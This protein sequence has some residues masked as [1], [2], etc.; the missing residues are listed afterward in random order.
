M[1]KYW[2][3]GVKSDSKS[4]KNIVGELTSSNIKKFL[5]NSNDIL[6]K[7]IYSYNKKIEIKAI[8]I[9]GLV[10][11]NAVDEYIL[12][13]LIVGRPFSEVKSEK[14]AYTIA[15]EGFLYHISQEDV[16]NLADAVT[17]ILEGNTVVVFDNIKK[18]FSFDAKGIPQRSIQEP[19]NES[20]L[21]GAKDGF[22]ENIRTNTALVRK[23]VKSTEIRFE[24]Y[25][26]GEETN[27]PVEIVYMN[28]VVDIGVLTKLKEKL[29]KLDISIMISSD[30]FESNIKD[31]KYSIFPQ[32]Q[33][34]ERVDKFCAN[35]CDGKVGILIDG[36]PVGYIVPG[37]FAMF[38][39]APED[40]AE[41]YGTASFLRSIRY[42]CFAISLIL[43]AFYVAITT[44]HHEM[45]PTNL[46]ISI[47]KSKEGVPFS[48]FFEILGLLVA[49]E[50]LLEASLRLPKTIGATISIIGGLIVGEA[51]VNAKFISPAVVVIIAITGIAGFVIPTRSL[52]NATRLCRM[53]LVFT[54]GV[55]GLFGISFGLLILLAYLCKLESF[56]VPYL[57]PYAGSEGKGIIHDSVLRLPE[58]VE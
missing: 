54:A 36:L 31:N 2:R 37:L 3:L 48:S 39:Q 14:E 17:K 25:T 34:T 57:T 49:F 30:N 47:I 19:E 56:G 50:L 27:T 26:I 42:V 24:S 51:A 10:D 52:S 35:I 4:N 55:S 28:D 53:L 15:K 43:P 7:D 45:I 44:F 29:S 16:K 32:I 40:Y 46:L 18:A 33:Y 41:N 1:F 9:D 6:V 11:S 23:K 8:G 21:K 22:V 20:V 38:L 5:G 13:P 58:D 12:K